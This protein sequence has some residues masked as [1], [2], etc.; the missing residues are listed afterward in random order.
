MNWS[1]FIKNSLLNYKEK[2]LWRTRKIIENYNGKKII[3]NKKKYINFSS[4]D[5][6][7]LSKNK[8]I[9][10]IC[11]KSIEKYG[12][13]SGGSGHITGYHNIHHKLENKISNWLGYPK[14]I[15][16]ISGYVANQ[17]VL[18]TLMKKNDFIFADKLIHSSLIDGSLFS[19]AQLKRFPH[20]RIDILKKLF[21]KKIIG[22]ILVVT[23]GVFSMDGDFSPLN[24]IQK[25]AIKN[26]AKLMVDDAHGIGVFGKYGKGS[27]DVYNI[28]PEFLIITFGKAFGL[29]GAALLC[30]SK[31]SDYFLQFS[32]HLI[33]STNMPPSQA[34]VLYKLVSKIKN[35][36]NLRKILKININYFIKLVK[37][38]NLPFLY[39]NTPI[40][41]LIIGNNERVLK[42]SRFLAKNGFWVQAIR[43]P[44]V[45]LS[46][47][48]LRI[49]LTANHNLNDI[50]HLFE[51]LN[52][53]FTN[54]S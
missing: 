7:G 6:L 12:L 44:T 5:Y 40:Q 51:I 21:K 18:T 13:G 46:M 52:K 29:S 49:T 36:D 15:L 19:Q 47:S 28:K 22:K 43:Y 8:E 26:K 41:P 35:S 30:N 48:R 27:C 24:K 34:F 39:S 32:K 42:L 50:E 53:F 16:F 1:K 31:M 10:K 33:Y 3:F 11:K 14:A 54:K 2:N 38:Y 17:S 37:H 9:I 20:N 23:E 25:L 4:N 45:P